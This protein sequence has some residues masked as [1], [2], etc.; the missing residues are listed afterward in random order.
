M[1]LQATVALILTLVLIFSLSHPNGSRTVAV[2]A[3]IAIVFNLAVLIRDWRAYRQ[4]K[5]LRGR[6]AQRDPMGW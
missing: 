1:L 2:L 5:R 4:E 6:L 3:G